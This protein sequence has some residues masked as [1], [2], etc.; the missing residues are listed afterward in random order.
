MPQNANYKL[1]YSIE[2]PHQELKIRLKSKLQ[3]PTVMKLVWHYLYARIYQFSFPSK[4][5]WW[6]QFSK[7]TLCDDESMARLATG[8]CYKVI[9]QE[10]ARQKYIEGKTDGRSNQ[11]P[12]TSRHHLTEW[13]GSD[14]WTPHMRRKLWDK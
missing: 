9:N 12:W 10:L 4:F 13:A 2:S 11:R 6:Q 5:K 7:R 14:N 1:I 3:K 8:V